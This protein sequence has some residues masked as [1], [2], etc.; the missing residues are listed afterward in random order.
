MSG[1]CGLHIYTH[2][3]TDWVKWFDSDYQRNKAY[4]KAKR[5]VGVAKTRK[6]PYRYVKK[7]G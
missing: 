5:K 3:G 2:N 7:V 4:L 1:R 6:T